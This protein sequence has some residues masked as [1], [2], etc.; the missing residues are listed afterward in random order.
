MRN[1]SL[2]IYRSRRSTQTL[3]PSKNVTLVQRGMASPAGTA[4]G[5]LQCFIK[6]G[7]EVYHI[8]SY[9]LST[10]WRMTCDVC[11]TYKSK[12]L[13]FDRFLQHRIVIEAQ[14]HFK[15]NVLRD[16]FQGEACCYR[17][18]NWNILIVNLTCQN[19]K[20]TQIIASQ[21]TC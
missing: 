1:S 14:S 8:S 2:S 13:T 17:I 3:A 10:S 5:I 15:D 19:V 12:T 21:H 20:T 9:S 7:S 4:D 16:V 11:F 6:D 18:K